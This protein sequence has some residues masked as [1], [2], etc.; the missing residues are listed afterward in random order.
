MDLQK[1]PKQF[2]ENITVGFAKEFFVMALISGQ[3]AGVY[4][5]TPQHA[6]RL[7]QYLTKTVADYEQKHG[8]IEAEWNP[9]VKSPIQLDD[10]PGGESGGNEQKS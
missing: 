3:N 7:Q 8:E 6:K 1:A 9:N 4:S 5:L 2:C 10:V